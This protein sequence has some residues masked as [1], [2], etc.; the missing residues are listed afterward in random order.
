MNDEFE[1]SE[2]SPSTFDIKAFLYKTLSYWKL[3][4]LCIGIGLFIVYQQNI[5]TQQSYKL[6]T[7]ISIEDDNNPLFSA[8]T[9]LTFN[10]GGVSGKVKTIITTLQSRSHHE[11]VVDNLQFYITYL[12]QARFR[13]DD[14]YKAAPFTFT[15]LPNT[16][17]VLNVPVRISIVNDTTFEIGLDFENTIVNTQNFTN[18]E[19]STTD[20]SIGPFKQRFK[21]GDPIILPFL[22]GTIHFKK[23]RKIVSGDEYFITFQNYDAVVGKYKDKLWVDNPANSSILNLEM[24]DVNTGKI[25]DYLNETVRVLSEDQLNRKNQFVTNTITFID[26]QLE[27]VKSQLT[28]NADS[29]NNYRQNNKIFNLDEESLQINEK[30]AKFEIEK[31]NT[32]RQ[33]AYYSNLKTYLETSNSFTDVPAPSI[34]G[35]NDA[36][37]L[38]NVSKLNA[39]SVQKSK[40]ETTVRS[41]AAIFGDIDRQTEGLKAVLLE[42]ISSASNGLR[43]EMEFINSKIASID[44]KIRKLPK[45]QQNMLNIERQ[46]ALSEQTYNVFLA[47]RGEAEIIK[48][49]SVSD[50]LV[51]DPAKDT[52]AQPIDLKLS[53]RYIFAIIGGFLP[54]LLLA[55]L[56]AFFDTKLHSPHNLEQISRIPLLG[57]IGKNESDNNLVVHNKPKS[58]IAESFRSIRS[59]LQFMYRTKGKEGSKTIVVTSSVSGEG[60]TFCSINLATVFALSGKKTV[61]VGLDLRKPKIFGDFKLNNDLGVVNYLIGQNTLDEVIN[62]SIIDNLDIITSGPIPPNPSELLIGEP[63]DTLINE[64]KTRYDYIILDTPP[65][66]LVA[67]ALELFEYADAS[68]YV[69]RQDYTKKAMLNFINDKYKK[70][71][72]SNISFLYNHY[73]QKGKYG[74]GHGYGY[75][76]YGNGPYGNGY[77]DNY[78]PKPSL[79]ERVKGLFKI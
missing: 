33:L 46:Y 42:N 74:Y 70:K 58:T 77:H 11:K 57:V 48:S 13:K 25:E 62:L 1:F 6:G 79:K 27:R 55:F 68:M 37:I 53:S 22:N 32:N 38:G 54:P 26:E 40:Y 69:V 7:Q 47:K 64:L 45:D 49:A 66:A 56:V 59:S 52:G 39:L 19:K 17:Q 51:I 72:L 76:T 78:K 61:L 29:L 28:L 15:L 30:L 9:S 63:M 2:S 3:F 44:S 34:A 4:I 10:W 12:K 14:I 21:F 36:N 50:V 24:T 20:V 67:D 8:N 5:R 23:D 60:K 35:V 31:D 71:E 75:A 41:D 73:D 16:S 18:K 65:V 43:R